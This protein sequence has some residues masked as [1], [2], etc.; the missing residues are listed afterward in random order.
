MKIITLTLALIF[1]GSCSNMTLS[2]QK[3][4]I[5]SEKCQQPQFIDSKSYFESYENCMDY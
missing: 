5:A 1:L 2:P 4:T 3:R